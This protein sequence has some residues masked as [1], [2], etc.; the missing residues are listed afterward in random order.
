[1]GWYVHT[2]VHRPPKLRME[3]RVGKEVGWAPGRSLGSG[4]LSSIVTVDFA[5]LG[6]VDVSR[7]EDR[8]DFV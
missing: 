8:T 6:F 1:M 7:K 4:S 2:C 3:L 5:L